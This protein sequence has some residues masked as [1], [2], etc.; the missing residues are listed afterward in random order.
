MFLFWRGLVLLFFFK[1]GS[2]VGWFKHR[3]LFLCAFWHSSC[4]PIARQ[5]TKP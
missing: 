3:V 4:R 1:Y 5:L 2:V